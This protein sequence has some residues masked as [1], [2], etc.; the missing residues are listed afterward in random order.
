M[1]EGEPVPVPRQGGRT[2]LQGVNVREVKAGGKR[3]RAGRE[4]H[5]MVTRSG[6]ELAN[7]LGT[8]IPFVA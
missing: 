1:Y 4:L 2:K 7:N 3:E 6:L 8:S 5:W